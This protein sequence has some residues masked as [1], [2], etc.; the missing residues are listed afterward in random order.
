M[1]FIYYTPIKNYGIVEMPA[2]S[3]LPLISLGIK[4]YV[5]L[6]QDDEFAKGDEHLIGAWTPVFQGTLYGCFKLLRDCN[7]I[8]KDE[9]EAEYKL[10]KNKVSQPL[11]TSE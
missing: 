1:N 9:M 6:K 7:I 5:I 2:S 10:A 4:S 8:S 11:T 3:M